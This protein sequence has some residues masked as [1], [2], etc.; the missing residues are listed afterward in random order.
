ME[1]SISNDRCRCIP[2]QKSHTVAIHHYTSHTG[3]YDFI[4]PYWHCSHYHEGSGPSQKSEEDKHADMHAGCEA[5]PR[6]QVQE[7][8]DANGKSSTPSICKPGD[9]KDCKKATSL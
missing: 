5:N 6:D 4:H 9:G 2:Y 7:S 8:R 1:K 3:R